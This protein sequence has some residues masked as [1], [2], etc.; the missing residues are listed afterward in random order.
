MNKMGIASSMKELTQD[1]ASSREDR[2]KMLLEVREEAKHITE[3][4]RNLIKGF[5]TSRGKTAAQ[6][7]KDLAGDKASRK[8]DVRKMLGDAQGLI[9]GFQASRKKDGAQ[10]RKGLA[11]GKAERRSEVSAILGD[12]RRAIG[13]FQ[14]QR[15]EA[16]NKLREELA[17][18]RSTRESEVG[19]LLKELGKSRQETGKKLRQDLAEGKAD[20]ESQVKEMRSE[21][22]KSQVAVRSD[23]NEARAA[24]QKLTRRAVVT[25]EASKVEVAEAP[26]AEKEAPDL[27]AKLLAAVREHP[28]GITLAKVA[29][30]LGV[31]PIILGRAS[32]KLVD[33]G[34]IRK[35]DKAY[36]PIASK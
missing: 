36:Y 25:A 7:R 27:E 28:A 32:R 13:S 11:Q 4:T 16:G 21:F 17:Q 2:V 22:H 5:E 1:I 12:A 33:E 34:K 14:S 18:G 6:L 24:W 23:I 3:D 19:E 15:K 26:P 9:K 31:T 20:R 35:E 30:R 10:L 8:S 29:K